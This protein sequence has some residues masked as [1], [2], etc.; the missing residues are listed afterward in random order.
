MD[1]HQK[2]SSSHQIAAGRSTAD[3]IFAPVAPLLRRLAL[4][5]KFAVIVMLLFLPL[6]AL[7]VNL[8]VRANND[9][10]YTKGELQGGPL[11]HELLDLANVVSNLRGLSQ[12]AAAGHN[13]AQA[14]LVEARA[15]LGKAVADNHTAITDHAGL[16]LGDVWGPLKSD[17]ERLQGRSDHGASFAEHSSLIAR[18]LVL[19]DLAA[20]NSGL[21]LDPEAKTFYLMDMVFE[22]EG[23]YAEAVGRLF[24]ESATPLARGTWTAEDSARMQEGIAAVTQA[25]QSVQARVDALVR[26]QEP[27]PEGWR[28]ATAAVDSAIAALSAVAKVG[29]VSVDAMNLHR[30]GQQA[31][32]KV[33]T[34]HNQAHHHLTALLEERLARLQQ[35]R[36]VLT[37][38]TL[39][40][41]GVALYFFLAIRRSIQVTAQATIAAA[42][43]LAQGNLDISLPTDARDEFGDI[44]RAFEVARNNLRRLT[45]DMNRMSREHDLGDIDV[46]IPAEDYHGEYRVMA[47]GI[48]NMVGGHIAVKKKAM[49]CFQSFGEGDFEAPMEQLPGKKAFINDTVE[50]VR[51]NLKRLGTDVNRLAVNIQLGRL[52]ARA[53]ASAQPGDFGRLTQ[54]INH[55]LDRITSFIDQMPSPAFVIDRDFSVQYINRSGAGLG[56]LDPK[57]AVGRKCFD[58]FKA[59]D[60]HTE[61]CA[62]SRAMSSGTAASS[63]TVAKPQ[64]GTFEIAYTGV[65]IRDGQG[66]I[67]GAFE[68]INDET[69]VRSSARVSAQVSD[70]QGME[71]RK[72][73]QTLQQLAEG[74]LS[75]SFHPD[76]GDASTET[77]HQAFSHI[78]EALNS[79]VSTLSST[80]GEVNTAARQLGSAAEQVSTTSQSLSQSASEQAAGVEETTAS[81]QEMASSIQQNSHSASVTDGMA[82]KAAREAI[83][84]GQAVTQT[85]DAM[86]AIATKIS[87]VD[88]IAYQTNLLALNAAIEAARAGEHGKG[89]AVVAAEVRKLAERSQVAAQEI[90]A[91]AGSSVQLAEKAGSLLNQMVPSI[92]KTSELVQEIAAASGEQAGSVNQI[93]SAMGHLNGATQQN[94]SAS[95]QL[96]ATAEELSAQ[97]EQLQG[98]MAFFQLQGEHSAPVS[99]ARGRSSSG[100][101]PVRRAQ[102]GAAA[103]R[104]P[105]HTIDDADM[106]AERSSARSSTA[107]RSSI[108]ESSFTRF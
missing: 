17:L 104:M 77:A 69:S 23:P 42:S 40:A 50:K 93:T 55:A 49:A 63:E 102:P 14:A 4:S 92:H 89:F 6:A 57:D 34:F 80:I 37:T 53:D 27:V 61:R 72:L 35:E 43:G 83:E 48:N 74:D 81:L 32:E 66:G 52:S 15:E 12:M 13:G 26:T 8:V 105:M 18:V 38:I 107:P 67:V 19:T 21:L 108:D 56:G 41:L 75:A 51:G 5:G 87:I 1:P 31:L 36:L 30:A 106:D 54:G 96:S 79:F 85:V 99:A 101:R 9:V 2:P 100:V 10:S 58:M 95:E 59:G 22:R 29:P 64:A 20:E 3:A 86:K 62:C 46:V 39:G 45:T 76:A 47:Q 73:V 68:F 84:G 91:L 24:A 97:A 71:A 98:L 11:A 94:A 28:D 90:G 70:Y 25:Q 44:S 16:K 65:P 103:T 78:A 60:C 82:T 88:D 7:M 33:D